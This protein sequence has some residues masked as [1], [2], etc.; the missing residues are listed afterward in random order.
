[1]FFAGLGHSREV[2]RPAFVLLSGLLACA[3]EVVERPGDGAVAPPQGYVAPAGCAPCHARQYDESLQSVMSGYRSASPLMNALELAGNFAAQSALEQGTLRNNLRPVYRAGSDPGAPTGENS[4]SA[5][6]VDDADEA[7]AAFCIGCH[8]P[9]TILMGEMQ[10]RREV[11]EWTGRFGA[12]DPGCVETGTVACFRPIEGARPLRDYHLVDA[13]GAQVLPARPGGPPPAGARPSISA[14][15]ISCDVCHCARGPDVDR[16]LQGDGFANGAFRLEPGYYKVGPF[17]DALPAGPAP[18]IGEPMSAHISSADPADVAYIRSS[19]FCISCHDVRV[20][21]PNLLV[22][23]GDPAFFRL[24]NLGTEWARQAYAQPDDN[25]FGQVVRCQ[26]CHMSL[27][28]YA[29]EVE[30]AVEDPGGAPPMTVRSPAPG[31]FAVAKA[32]SGE[33]PTGRGLAL[34]DR[35]VVN[36]YFTGVDLPFLETEQMRARL[37]ADRPSDDEPGVDAF[38]VPRSLRARRRDLLEAAVRLDL[39]RTDD[40]A[41]LGARFDVRVR[42]VALTGHN[43]PAGFSQE[44]TTWIELEVVG[45]Q[46]GGAPFTLYHSGYRVDRAHPETGELAPDGRLADEDLPHLEAVVNPFTHDNDV[47]E[48]GPD[49]GPLGRIFEGRPKGLVLL[50]NELIRVYGPAEIDGRPTGIPES[51]RRHPRTG[52]LLDH[53][54]EEETFSAAVANGV[55]NWR[56]LLPLEP[57][58]FRYAVELPSASTLAALGVELTGDVEVKARLH[59]QQFPPLFLRFLAR[60]SGAAPYRMPAPSRRV[61]GFDTAGLGRGDFVGRRGPA[62]L[63]FTL[64]DEAR[65]D[66]FSNVV[67][68]IAVAERAVPLEVSP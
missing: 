1:M 39:S 35:E 63:D 31:R 10:A 49:A 5:D 34:P 18:E 44:R 52:A 4:V 68:D 17:A 36:H 16:S 37:G 14:H 56:A 2:R 28:P 57:R 19:G 29:G 30:Y 33:D 26:D 11:P 61:P 46:V 7:R 62:D 60:V 12:P 22:P 54:I 3:P 67:Q 55:D 65:I 23:E 24:E 6:T 38:G 9:Q 42:A 53:V 32:A 58:T 8:A 13:D 43:F 59:F 51:N 47:F 45:T 48:L 25:P 27:Y 50:R 20:P 41:R 64:I 21:N 40:V 66:R 15:G